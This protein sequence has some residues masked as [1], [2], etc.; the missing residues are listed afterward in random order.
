MSGRA[1]RLEHDIDPAAEADAT[2]KRKH[3]SKRF[4]ERVKLLA[5]LLNNSGVA[6]LA[7][8]V[9]LPLANGNISPTLTLLWIPAV[10]AL[11]LLAQI[12]LTLLR[13]ED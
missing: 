11:H 8:V 2:R 5:T 3:A 9:I 7:G 6:T 4:N 13:S 12:V 1:I 10:I